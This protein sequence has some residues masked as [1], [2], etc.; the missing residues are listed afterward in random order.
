M[1]ALNIVDDTAMDA[2][3]SEC[4]KVAKQGELLSWEASTVMGVE[5]FKNDPTK[6]RKFAIRQLKAMPFATAIFC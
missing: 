5:K 1:A 6:L 2:L 4:E 3:V